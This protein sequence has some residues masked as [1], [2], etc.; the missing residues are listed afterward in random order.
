MAVK[1]KWPDSFCLICG[2]LVSQFEFICAKCWDERQ[3]SS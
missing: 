2:V 1:K 3:G